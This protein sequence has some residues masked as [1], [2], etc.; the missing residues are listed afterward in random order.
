[1]G[2][3]NIPILLDKYFEGSSSLEEEAQLK[4]FFAQDDIS[5]DLAIYRPLFQWQVKE[6]EIELPAT[7]EANLLSTIEQER[8]PDAFKRLLLHP[9]SRAAAVVFLAVGMWWAYQTDSTTAVTDSNTINWAAYEPKTPEEALS[10][11]REAMIMISK[12][13]NKG[14]SRV[15]KEVVKVRQLGRI[16]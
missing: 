6:Q 7:F 9:M 2:Y 1:M 11:T 10:I 16:D 8:R 5:E 15:A 3:D 13:L 12:E 4:A 14:T